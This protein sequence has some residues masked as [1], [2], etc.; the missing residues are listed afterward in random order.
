MNTQHN[1]NDISLLARAKKDRGTVTAQGLPLDRV[2][3]GVVVHQ[4]PLHTDHRGAL[5]EMFTRPEFWEADFAYAYQTSIRPGMLKGWY[6]HEKKLDRYHLVTGELLV[7]LYDD[8]ENSPTRGLFQK[9]VLSEATARQVLI[10][11]LVWHLSLNIG[12]TDAILVNLPSTH[13]DHSNPDRFHLSIDSGDIPVD[14]RAFF[15]VTLS[16]PNHVA[17]SLC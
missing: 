15:P 10:P 5:V 9:L 14:V 3:E 8:R 13:Y 6:A 16:S 4:P 2:I 7:L 1:A 11:P 17:D 12:Q